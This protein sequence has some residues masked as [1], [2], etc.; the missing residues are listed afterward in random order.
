M[1]E[2]DAERENGLCHPR[3]NT[4]AE[5]KGGVSAGCLF[6]P[7]VDDN[8]HLSPHRRE[9][10][11]E[12]GDGFATSPPLCSPHVFLSRARMRACHGNKTPAARGRRWRGGG[13]GGGCNRHLLCLRLGVRGQARV[14]MV[15]STTQSRL[16]RT[17]THSASSGGMSAPTTPP[18]PRP[19]H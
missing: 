4:R 19:P 10:R 6:Q 13:E 17:H 18:P 11:A 8:S 3:S 2:L 1:T 9:A 16:T 15:R 14:L 7:L 5:D 12:A